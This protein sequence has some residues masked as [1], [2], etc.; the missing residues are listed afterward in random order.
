MTEVTYHCQLVKKTDQEKG[1]NYEI[2][3]VFDFVGAGNCFDFA[4]FALRRYPLYCDF[5]S[6][7]CHRFAFAC[8][9]VVGAFVR[10]DFERVDFVRFVWS[11][12]RP[13]YGVYG[14][15]FFRLRPVDFVRL[16]LRF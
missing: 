5:A 10:F 14:G 2:E 12:F 13:L 8:F 15:V 1:L 7:C 6:R 9:G 16:D 3:T 4:A 11:R